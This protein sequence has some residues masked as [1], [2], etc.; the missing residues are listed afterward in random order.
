M[1]SKIKLIRTE[2]EVAPCMYC[3]SILLIK[4]SDL[5]FLR[6]GYQKFQRFMFDKLLVERSVVCDLTMVAP[7]VSS[8]T[9]LTVS[10]YTRQE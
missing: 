7:H 10:L 4:N 5:S 2:S 1:S 8:P 6:F 9:L 3:T